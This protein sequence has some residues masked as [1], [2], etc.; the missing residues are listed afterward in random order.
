MYSITTIFQKNSE[1][2]A[3]ESLEYLRGL[4]LIAIKTGT[5]LGFVVRSDNEEILFFIHG[6]ITFFTIKD[7]RLLFTTAEGNFYEAYVDYS[8][9]SF[10]IEKK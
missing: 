1:K 5:Y 7:K 3:E 8:K 9:T 4:I 2:E 6:N 10:T